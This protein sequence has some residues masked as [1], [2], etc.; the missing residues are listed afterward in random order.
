[1]NN[2]HSLS[3]FRRYMVFLVSTARYINSRW[4]NSTRYVATPLLAAGNRG[5]HGRRRGVGGG[6]RLSLYDVYIV[7]RVF[8]VSTMECDS[9]MYDGRIGSAEMCSSRACVN[10]LHVSR[11]HVSYEHLFIITHRVYTRIEHVAEG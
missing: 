3:L 4:W 10:L 6:S 2:S 7:G 9:V 1:M 8:I 5:E 11:P